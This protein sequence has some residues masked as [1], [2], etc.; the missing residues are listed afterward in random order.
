MV[1]FY[2]FST[3]LSYIDRMYEDRYSQTSGMFKGISLCVI[4]FVVMLKVLFK[5]YETKSKKLTN[6]IK[7]NFKYIS[8]FEK[9]SKRTH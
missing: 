3:S 1:T 6:G 5:V 4:V 7:E 2:K 8:E 9:A